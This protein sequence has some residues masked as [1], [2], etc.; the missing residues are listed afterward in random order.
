MSDVV[1]QFRISAN[2]FDFYGR[3]GYG[4]ALV[5]NRKVFY[6]SYQLPSMLV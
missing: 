1:S 3:L 6:I 2:A 4:S 5:A